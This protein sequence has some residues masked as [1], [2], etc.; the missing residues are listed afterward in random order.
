MVAFYQN[1]STGT[2][3]GM[4]TMGLHGQNYNVYMAQADKYAEELLKLNKEIAEDPNNTKLLERREELLE[5]QRDSI[6]AAEDEKQAI[7][8]M[9]REGIE[10]ELDALQDLIDRYTESLDSAKSLYDYQKKIKEQTSEIASLQ[11]QIA[12]YA[13]DTSEENRATVQKLQVDLSDAMEDLEETQ[14][15]HYISEQKKLLDNL[16]DEYEMILN[17]RLDNIDATMF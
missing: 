16:Y 11:K 2:D 5:A 14:Y 9:V 17:E 7:V 8:D 13:G 6:L 10:L 12:A 15:D 1:L 3:T 4:A